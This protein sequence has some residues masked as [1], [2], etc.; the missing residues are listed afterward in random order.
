M[1]ISLEAIAIR[2]E[3]IAIRFEAIAIRFEA[4]AIRLEAI[5]IRLEAIAIRFEAI[6]IRLEAIAIRFEVI[7][8]RFESI[9]IRLEAIAIRFE[10]IA[11]RFESIA[12]RL[13]AIAIRLVGK[14]A[15]FDVRVFRFFLFVSSKALVPIRHTTWLA[16]MLVRLGPRI[17][18][19][20]FALL[21]ISVPVLDSERIYST[22]RIAYPSVDFR[23]TPTRTGGRL[24]CGQ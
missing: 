23:H 20:C 12:I 4:I 5:A 15:F 17:H 11:I 7:A 24:V 2:L 6:A 1:Y 13:E 8:I 19:R 18:H 3:A 21:G 16:R 10:V 9:A 22:Q 14:S